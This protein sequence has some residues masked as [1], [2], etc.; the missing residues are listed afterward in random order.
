M[1]IGDGIAAPG[2]GGGAD[3]PTDPVIFPSG[4][5][6]AIRRAYAAALK[7]IDVEADPRAFVTL[8]EAY[9]AALAAAERAPAPAAPIAAPRDRAEAALLQLERALR[10]DPSGAGTALDILLEPALVDDIDAAM[11]V[12]PWLAALLLDTVPQSTGM[13]GRVI[14]AFGWDVRDPESGTIDRILQL[15]RVAQAARAHQARPDPILALLR[16]PFTPPD[17]HVGKR[18]AGDVRKWLE[19]ADRHPHRLAEV[20]PEARAWWEAHAERPRPWIEAIKVA[21][22]SFLF[23]AAAILLD[24]GI[25][26]GAWLA[27]LAGAAMAAAALSALRVPLRLLRPAGARLAANEV[28]A[29]AAL[30]LLPGVT[31]FVAQELG[32]AIGIGLLGAVLMLAIAEPAQGPEAADRFHRM[33]APGL[34]PLLWLVLLLLQARSAAAIIG[35]VAMLLAAL[36]SFR[37]FDRVQAALA[38]SEPL[39]RSAGLAVAVPALALLATLL[40]YPAPALLMPLAAA[41]ALLLLPQ[42]L[43]IVTDGREMITSPVTWIVAAAIAVTPALFPSDTAPWIP[44]WLPILVNALIAWRALRH[45]RPRYALHL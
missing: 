21:G 26:F 16:A 25:A 29:L 45:L 31:P 22:W 43:L 34:A 38:G 15:N 1:E 6:R 18:L 28:L 27:L 10:H 4:D 19:H 37:A 7:A 8:R 13:L 17:R 36:G 9:E 30:L 39:R 2:I 33:L 40:L 14:A 11:I 24:P 41:T 5:A 23:A 12:E 3:F 32:A 20:D 35:S 42:H 44:R